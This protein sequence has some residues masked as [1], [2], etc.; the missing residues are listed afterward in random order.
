[1]IIRKKSIVR[2]EYHKDIHR[3]SGSGWI[4]ISIIRTSLQRGK[5][6]MIATL[7]KT[8]CII[9]L[10]ALPIEAQTNDSPDPMNMSIEDLMGIK[11][12]GASKFEQKAS[13]APA[14]VSIVTADEI[15]KYG[16]RTFA[17]IL[18]SIRGFYITYDRNYSYMGLRGFGRTGDYNSR[19]LI[20][21]DGHR[22]N[23]NIYDSVLIGT[24]FILDIDLIS[25]VEVIRGPGFSLYGSNAFLG[26][27][28]IITK[29]GNDFRG[30]EISGEAGSFRSYKGRT[31]AGGLFRN[32]LDLVVSGSLYDSKGRESLY[33]REFDDPATSNGVTENT[34]Y[35]RYHSLFAKTSLGDLSLEGAYVSRTKGIPTASYETDFNEPRNRTVDTQGFLDLKYQ[36]DF[37]REY[38][39]I[40]RLSYDVYR[41]KGD[42]LYSGVVNNDSCLGEWW[43][44]EVH[45]TARPHE[46]HRL[47]T[48]A[49][50]QYNS[51]QDQKNY[52]ED[53]FTLYL[54]DRR[55]SKRWAVYLQD[56]F[57]IT[58]TLLANFGARYERTYT[59]KKTINPRVALIYNPSGNTSFKFIYGEA[60]RPPNLY[61]LYF[62]DNVSIKPNPDLEPERIRTYE[63]VYEQRLSD[64]I[65]MTAT[66]F[67]YKIKDLINQVIDPNDG[68]MVFVNNGEV[69]AT[70]IELEVEGKWGNGLQGRISYAY[71]NATDGLTGGTPVNSPHH[72]VNVNVIVPVVRNKIFL[73]AETQYT[74]SVKTL[75]GG[76]IDG[77]SLTNLTLFSQ[78]LVKGLELSASVYNLF[79]KKYSF[80]GG[81]EHVMDAIQQDGR[82][83]RVKLTYAF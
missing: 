76:K 68:L 7:L 49:E 61:E 33:Y 26:V 72:L 23:D 12:Y 50:Y 83:F 20:L 31:S 60:F 77:F 59:S 44:G 80:P 27:I 51:K 79:N 3:P 73:G 32:G 5:T 41:S 34:D 53:P 81:P 18:R 10:L 30:G 70:G 54:D 62:H 6:T 22:L 46:R 38:E 55:S 43:T 9:M 24:D 19:F 8:M 65:S 29:S 36:H 67:Y 16:Y 4:R 66:G 2:D 17:D 35:D 56:E 58:D 69:K 25:R 75:G 74:S 14:S 28:N 48:G 45:F 1:M 39:L 11:V 82:S 47:L 37:G 57:R 13:E 42:Y 21:I 78:K 52:D 63:L 40:A 64:M 15:R 71:T